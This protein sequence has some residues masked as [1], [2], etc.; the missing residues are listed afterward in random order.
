MR[1]VVPVRRRSTG[2]A[3]VVTALV[4]GLLLA[5][6]GTG[7]AQPPPPCIN[8]VH[9][10]E[11]GRVEVD[12]RPDPDTGTYS[13]LTVFWFI[14]D[15]EARPGIYHWTHIVNGKPGS[16]HV[17]LKD[18]N[19]HTAFKAREGWFFGDTYKFQATHYSP[20]TQT[21][22]VAAVNECLITPR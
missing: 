9:H 14:N 4:V 7:S 12:L 20:A 10:E 1:V 2:R 3:T 18:D 16:L 8:Y 21:T 6:A 13:T 17:E 22:Y 11:A 5:T 15:V 19:V